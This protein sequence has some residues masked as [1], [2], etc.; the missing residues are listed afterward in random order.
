[1]FNI[2]LETQNYWDFG[3]RLSSG[4]LKTRKVVNNTT[5]LKIRIILALFRTI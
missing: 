2:I 5:E 4:I 3:L 1:M